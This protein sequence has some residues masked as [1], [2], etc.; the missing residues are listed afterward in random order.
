MFRVRT[1]SGTSRVAGTHASGVELACCREKRDTR[2]DVDSRLKPK[3][4]IHRNVPN[5]TE[6]NF[7]RTEAEARQGC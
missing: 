7:H 2:H 5:E 3:I 4:D 1:N 6:S